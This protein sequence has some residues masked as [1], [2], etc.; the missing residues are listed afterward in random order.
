MCG[1]TTVAMLPDV[2]APAVAC[3]RIMISIIFMYLYLLN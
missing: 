1:D 2:V 3:S